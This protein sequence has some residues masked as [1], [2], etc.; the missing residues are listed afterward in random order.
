MDEPLWET[1]SIFHS[2]GPKKSTGLTC[3]ILRNPL[4][5]YYRTLFQTTYTSRLWLNTVFS[6]VHTTVEVRKK[7]VIRKLTNF[8]SYSCLQ[9]KKPSR[10][11]I[12]LFSWSLFWG[13]TRNPLY[14]LT[15]CPPAS[16]PSSL[17]G[18]SEKKSSRTV[19][20]HKIPES[21]TRDCWK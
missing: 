17:S 5:V 14:L 13:R 4:L 2:F 20:W 18:T 21:M 10:P 19:S 16:T 1:V 6:R 15:L 8:G 9:K 7:D 3:R 12:R 11:E